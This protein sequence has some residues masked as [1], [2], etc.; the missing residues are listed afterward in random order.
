MPVFLVHSALGS[1]GYYA[2]LARQLGR[3]SPLYGINSVGLFGD[4]A[5]LATC[6]EMASHYIEEIR[7]VIPK[8][9][10]VFAGHSSGS[11]IAFEM[12][13]RLAEKEAPLCVIIDQLPPRPVAL[14]DLAPL[15]D[16]NRHVVNLIC[17]I[18]TFY[19]Q[20][21]PNDPETLYQELRHRDDKDQLGLIAQWL[22]QLR[23]L[24]TTATPETA[25]A[26]LNVISLNYVAA[27]RWS[28]RDRTYEGRLVVIN[29]QDNKFPETSYAKWQRFCK[30]EIAMSR[31]PGNHVSLMVPP[32][33]H[34]LGE[35]V[36]T[37]LSGT[38]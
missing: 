27:A 4:A 8:G 18:A 24:P 2:N 12:C 9:P 31:V 29:V 30:Q 34:A 10:Y 3:E 11:Y 16:L 25:A 20:P 28:P 17:L 7:R 35:R 26:Y 15:G 22:R 19:G 6:E 23:L 14:A 13:L 33:V 21:P 38:A 32:D 5:P 36:T 1:S 37:A